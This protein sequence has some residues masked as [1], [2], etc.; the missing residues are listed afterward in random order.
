M[1]IHLLC[2]LHWIH[3]RSNDFANDRNDIDVGD[4]SGDLIESNFS[5]LLDL[6]Y[7]SDDE[8]SKP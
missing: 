3:I 8:D 5:L 4:G 1:H 6:L 2:E 7:D